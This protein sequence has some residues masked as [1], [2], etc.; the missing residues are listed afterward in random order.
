IKEVTSTP[1]VW[2]EAKKAIAEARQVILHRLNLLEWLSN[3]VKNFS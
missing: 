3:Y 1:D 2:H